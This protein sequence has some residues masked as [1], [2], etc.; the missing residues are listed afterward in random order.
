MSR[1]YFPAKPSAHLLSDTYLELVCA[2]NETRLV[3]KSPSMGDE[4]IAV[5]PLTPYE[6]F[7][8]DHDGSFTSRNGRTWWPEKP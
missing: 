1:T 5:F 2:A 4:V 8:P 7:R 3:L 6:L